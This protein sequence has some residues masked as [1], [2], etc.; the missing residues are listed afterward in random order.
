MRSMNLFA[1]SDIVIS[2][3]LGYR[4]AKD[5]LRRKTP[6]TNEQPP[7]KKLVNL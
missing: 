7:S 1:L 4:Q 3:E 6:P 2:A 5:I